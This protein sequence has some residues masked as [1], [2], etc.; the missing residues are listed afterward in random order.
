MKMITKN[1]YLNELLKETAAV[2]CPNLEFIIAMLAV[3]LINVRTE[4]FSIDRSFYNAYAE[5]I[6]ASCSENESA[7]THQRLMKNQTCASNGKTLSP[8]NKTLINSN[9]LIVRSN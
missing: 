6:G 4:M 3:I 8:F 2:K 7:C 5:M 9:E 1:D